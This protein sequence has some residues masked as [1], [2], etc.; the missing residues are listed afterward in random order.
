MEVINFFADCPDVAALHKG[1]FLECRGQV[2]VVILDVFVGFSVQQLLQLL[3]VKAEQGEVKGVLLQIGQFDRQHLLIPSG[4]EGELVVREDAGA[5]LR[6][7]QIL[8]EDARYGLV[9]F[10]TGS[11]LVRFRHVLA[12][13]V[14]HVQDLAFLAQKIPRRF[15]GKRVV[16]ILTAP[17][18]V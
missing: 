1:C 17:D 5:F 6:V 8:G 11:L 12:F 9:S 7:G 14:R 13:G 3:V 18:N 2:E 16:E 15:P 4:V 10:L